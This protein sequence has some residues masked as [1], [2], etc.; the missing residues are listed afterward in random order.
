MDRAYILPW[1]LRTLLLLPA[2]LA[3][4]I[5]AQARCQNQLC[6]WS[7][8]DCWQC[9]DGAGFGCRVDSCT[10][11][12]NST[13]GGEGFEPENGVSFLLPPC[14]SPSPNLSSLGIA[15]VYPGVLLRLPVLTA[16]HGDA[17]SQPA[18]TIFAVSSPK[19]APAA[20]VSATHTSSDLLAGARLRNIG[21]KTIV[22]YRVGWE[23]RMPGQR[24]PETTLGVWMNVPPGI[25][26][27]EFAQVPPQAVSIELAR[28]G[29]TQ[30]AFLVGEVKFSD[31]TTWRRPRDQ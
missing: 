19:G 14:G 21:R 12:T 24:K 9:G 23:V 17:V 3:L 22:G 1:L 13:C 4:S 8:E 10:S 30:I 2:F 16:V 11:C 7:G 18:R 28:R 5:P 31:G 27:G 25:P 15:G 20:L 26:P 6:A 29:A